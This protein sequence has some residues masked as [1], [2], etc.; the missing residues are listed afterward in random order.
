MNPNRVCSSC[1]SDQDLRAWVRSN[2]GP[3]G[4]DICCKFDSPTAEFDRIVEHIERCLRRY[5]GRAVDQLGYCSAEGGYLGAH[6]DSW[7]VLDKIGITSERDNKGRLYNALANSM[8]DEPW[9][10][11]DVATLDLDEALWTSWERFCRTVKHERRF[12]FHA[13][14][15]DDRDSLTPTSLLSNIAYTT[16][17]LELV[18]ELPPGLGFWRARS[19][20]EKGLRVKASDF[21]PPPAQFALQS[22]RMNPAGIPMLYLASSQTTALKETRTSSAKLGLWRT[23]RPIKILDLRRLPDVPG[24]F[25]E[26]ARRPA[27]TIRF[28]HDFAKDIMKPVARDHTVHID[29]LPSQV[30]TEFMRD[31][32]FSAGPLDG[33]AYRSTVHPKGWNLALFLGPI[34]LGLESPGWGRPPS[35]AFTFEKSIWATLP[36]LR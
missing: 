25:S 29:Y 7:D 23:A 32:A 35:I 20:L 1:F 17:E 14:G 26:F 30:V 34:D 18:K 36:Q 6:W 21:G 10:D 11:F 2:D 5:Y 9:C 22:N 13:T 28:L 24:M 16:E 8:T 12:F 3:R 15:R 31:Y 27:L 33:V 4:C 19:D